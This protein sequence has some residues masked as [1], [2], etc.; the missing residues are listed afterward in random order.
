MVRAVSHS[1]PLMI[2]E[3]HCALFCFFLVSADDVRSLLLRLYARVLVLIVFLG[4]MVHPLL[5]VT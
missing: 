5:R 2:V 3:V 4:L 1:L